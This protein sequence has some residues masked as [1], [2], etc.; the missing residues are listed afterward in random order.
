MQDLAQGFKRRGSCRFASS[1]PCRSIIHSCSACHAVCKRI[2]HK[3]NSIYSPAKYNTRT[4][5]ENYSCCGNHNFKISDSSTLKKSNE[6]GKKS[7]FHIIFFFLSHT[8]FCFAVSS[9]NRNKKKEWTC[10]SAFLCRSD[11]QCDVPVN[12]YL[13]GLPGTGCMQAPKYTA[14]NHTEQACISR[15]AHLAR[16][17]I[18]NYS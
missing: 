8:E 12:V 2:G 9:K 15:A 18:Q 16:I 17:T 11:M 1:G 10:Q 7:H 3:F 14:L 4:R 13:N 6:S 5:D